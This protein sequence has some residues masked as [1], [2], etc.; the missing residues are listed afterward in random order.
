VLLDEADNNTVL[1]DVLALLLVEVLAELDVLWL[2]EELVELVDRLEALDGLLVDDSTLPVMPRMTNWN[3]I[4][5]LTP[6]HR[7]RNCRIEL[8]T[9][10][11]STGLSS[12]IEPPGPIRLTLLLAP[13]GDVNGSAAL[14]GPTRMSSP[15][16][17][18]VFLIHTPQIAANCAGSPKM[19]GCGST[20]AFKSKVKSAPL[21]TAPSPSH[22]ISANGDAS[23]ANELPPV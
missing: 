14:S 3:A 18:L 8:D 7:T 11:T 4:D 20:P 16:T 6:A 23:E 13:Q 21:L 9:A 19:S 5:V 15:E 12:I 10:N 22:T 1:D 17:S 2:D